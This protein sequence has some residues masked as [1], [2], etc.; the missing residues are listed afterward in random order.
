MQSRIT[1]AFLH[2][3]RKIELET[4]AREMGNRLLRSNERITQCHV[5]IEGHSSTAERAQYSVKIHLSVACAQIHASSLYNNGE[6]SADVYSALRA[7]FTDAKRQLLALQVDRM[8][9]CLSG[10]ARARG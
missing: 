10:E 7:A 8:R 1:L 5:V 3:D 6:R 4:C 9:S 2:I